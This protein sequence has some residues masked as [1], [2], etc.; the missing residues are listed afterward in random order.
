MHAE[1][2]L[3]PEVGELFNTN[4]K[5]FNETARKWSKKHAQ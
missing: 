3:D 5:K 4:L 1:N 2:P